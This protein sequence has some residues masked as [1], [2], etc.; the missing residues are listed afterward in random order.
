V[1]QRVKCQHRRISPRALYRVHTCV[2]RVRAAVHVHENEY[3]IKMTKNAR[4]NN[5]NVRIYD[6]CLSFV[7]KILYA[8]TQLVAATATATSALP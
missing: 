4:S 3:N 6:G 5:S 2:T 8:A 7:V 1:Q